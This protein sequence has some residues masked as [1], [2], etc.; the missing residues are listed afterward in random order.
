MANLLSNMA[1]NPKTKKELKER[2][3]EGV[4]LHLASADKVASHIGRKVTVCP[5]AKIN[6]CD[7]P[8]L[9]EQGRGN[10]NTVKDARLRKT[11]QFFQDRAAFNQSM[12]SELSKLEKRAIKKGYTPVA[13]LDGTSDLGL[14]MKLCKEFPG[15]QMYDYTKVTARMKRWL[16]NKPDNLHMT[17]SL[18]AGNKSDALEILELGG[19]VAVVFRLRKGK[20]LPKKWNGKPVIDGDINDYRFLDPQGVVVGLRSKGTSY[21]DT[22]GFVQEVN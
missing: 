4:I 20:P 21:H 15:I 7:G 11:I 16:R 5:M 1:A 22:L 17:Y 18:G 10:M 6:K 19:N 12:H 14:S 3:I 13:R 8:C 9:D 2:K